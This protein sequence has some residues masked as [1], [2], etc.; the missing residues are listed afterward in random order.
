MLL[1]ESRAIMLC[2]CLLLVPCGRAQSSSVPA[3]FEV[4]A[5]KVNP[6]C[7]P[8]GFQRSPGTLHIECVTLEELIKASYASYADGITFNEHAHTA[9]V[10]GG[11]AWV[12]SEHYAIDAKA[13]V[14]ATVYQ[15]LGPMT[16]AL[17]EDRFKL[18]VHRTE[19]TVP[20]YLL[21]V[22]KKGAKLQKAREGGCLGVVD[23]KAPPPPGQTG[24][25]PCGVTTWYSS[26]RRIEA[27]ARTMKLF[28]DW[29]GRK[30]DRDV[31][32]ATDL[33]GAFD[34]RLEFSSDDATPGFG[35]E[36]RPTADSQAPSPSIFSALE[37][38][39]GLKLQPAKGTSEV[40]VIDHVERP[41]EN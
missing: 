33:E 16:R 41:S 27:H 14:P 19:K 1:D 23:G 11:P 17:I 6:S 4:A 3:R 9:E 5:I 25:P 32:D 28:A 18:K 13:D 12:T 8:N 38:Q 35:A 10:A 21:T 15:M 40:L 37:D 39:L 7:S 36:R 26:P 30:M 34:F 22:S 20:V 31:F 2:S 29:L 24:P